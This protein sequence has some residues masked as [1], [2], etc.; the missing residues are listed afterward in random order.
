MQE[1][2]LTTIT[3]GWNILCVLSNKDEFKKKENK[4]GGLGFMPSSPPFH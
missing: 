3:I 4:K 1:N 2:D